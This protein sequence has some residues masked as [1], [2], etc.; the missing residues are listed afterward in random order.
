MEFFF[1]LEFI[2]HRYKL[3]A[4]IY[5]KRTK[6][7]NLLLLKASKKVIVKLF[8]QIVNSHLQNFLQY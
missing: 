8:I 4:N 5:I 6:L 3:K 2:F 1:K 7:V